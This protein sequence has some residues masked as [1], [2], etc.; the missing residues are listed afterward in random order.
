MGKAVPPVKLVP[1][2]ARPAP[3]TLSLQLE[4]AYVSIHSFT[5]QSLQLAHRVAAPVRH[6][7]T[8]RNARL[9]RQGS[10]SATR[11]VSNAH[12]TKLL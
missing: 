4:I 2:I 7:M 12:L 1:T 10:L 9:A 5:T 3:P 8:R 6:V 11:F